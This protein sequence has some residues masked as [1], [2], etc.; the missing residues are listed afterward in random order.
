MGDKSKIEWC[1]ATWSPMTG[2]SAPMGPGCE[3]CWAERQ[4]RRQGLPFRA[5]VFHRQRL[6][7]PRHWRKPRRIFVCP[8]GDLFDGAVSRSF[9][10]KVWTVMIDTYRHRYMLLTK[11]AG[12]MRDIGKAFLG[13][14]PTA[15]PRHIWFGVSAEDQ[16]RFDARY[17]LIHEVNTLRFVSLEPLLGPIKLGP[18]PD[19]VIVGGESGP[20]ARPMRYEWVRD[21]RDQ[22]VAA[23]VPFVF[24][25]WGQYSPGGLWRSK[26]EIGRFLDGKEWLQEPKLE[27]VP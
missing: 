27:G 25:Q 26:K 6:D 14:F 22:C 1:D 2:C 8:M 13:R 24:K 9:I 20:K 17:P 23:D 3:N 11:R 12:G 4:L 21:I 10:H 15:S 16:K 19:W 7:Q 5:V 18:M